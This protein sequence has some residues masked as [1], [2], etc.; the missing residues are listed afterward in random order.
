VLI[1]FE[2]FFFLFLVIAMDLSIDT[3]HATLL[4]TATT[5]IVFIAHDESPV[6]L[7]NPT[8]HS[9]FPSPT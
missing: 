8:Q 7:P 6:A 5:T 3:F 9:Y 1:I 4:T 2:G